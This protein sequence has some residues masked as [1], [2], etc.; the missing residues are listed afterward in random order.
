MADGSGGYRSNPVTLKVWWAGHL[1][2]TIGLEPE[3]VATMVAR[4]KDEVKRGL[5]THR[6]CGVDMDVDEIVIDAHGP[7]GWKPI[8]SFKRK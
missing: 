2:R 5:I 8:D 3:E 7:N 6:S 1:I 4:L